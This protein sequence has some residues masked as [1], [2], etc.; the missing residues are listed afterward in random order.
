M[1]R[2]LART[3]MFQRVSLVL[4][5][6]LS[7]LA[8]WLRIRGNSISGVLILALLLA[9]FAFRKQLFWRV[10]NRLLLSYVLFG[11]VPIVLIG[12]LIFLTLELGLGPLGADRVRRVLE[13]R[14]LEVQA[15]AQDID[16]T[17]AAARS[18]VRER[19]LARIPRLGMVVEADGKAVADPPNGPSN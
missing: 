4:I 19:V 15:A 5:A 3:T 1:V 2:W 11:V 16:A 8:V 10:R 9:G 14:I 18:Y 17:P 13:T 7:V 6:A 12:L